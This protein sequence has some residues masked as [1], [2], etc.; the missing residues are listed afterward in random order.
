MD[1]SET[2]SPKSDQIDFDDFIAG[3]QTFTISEVRR[4]PSAE[5]PVEVVMK[6]F[7]RPWRPAKSM[8]RVLASVWTA[9]G[10][11]YVGKRITLF[12]DPTV[13]WGGQEVGGVRI[14]AMSGI[15]KPLTIPLT[16]TRGRRAPF[17]VQPLPDAPVPADQVS[18]AVTAVHGATS[19]VD[20]D[21]IVAHARKLGIDGA[22]ELVA[23]IGQKR[24]ELGAI[25]DHT[26]GASDERRG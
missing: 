18:K 23:A 11:T 4:G 14:R 22:V 9:D 16:V 26:D 21:K 25:T 19:T 15:D 2:L 10:A 20:L 17:T 24:G 7:P 6:E 5:Q 3:D 1:I 12:G 13:R 8:R